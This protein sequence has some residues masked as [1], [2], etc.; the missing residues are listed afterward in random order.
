MIN[1][2]IRNVIIVHIPIPFESLQIVTSTQITIS[3]IICFLE[4]REKQKESID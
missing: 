4:E 3:I 1:I 2:R